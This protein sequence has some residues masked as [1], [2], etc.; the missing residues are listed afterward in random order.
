[1]N[2]SVVQDCVG[3]FRKDSNTA[4]CYATLV[5]GTNSTHGK[6]LF[7]CFQ[8]VLKLVINKSPII[9]VVSANVAAKCFGLAFEVM[10]GGHGLFSVGG[11][12][13]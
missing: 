4:L 7:V 10:L 12:L 11:Q 6:R 13:V 1:M 2:E 9:S 8:V 5:V 3:P